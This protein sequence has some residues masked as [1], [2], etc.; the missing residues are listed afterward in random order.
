MHQAGAKGNS[1]NPRPADFRKKIVCSPNLN[2]PIRGPGCGA[3][4][5]DHLPGGPAQRAE[6][7]L[8][9]GRDQAVVVPQVD[10][11]GQARDDQAAFGRR[12]VH[13]PRVAD[14]LEDVLGE[15]D[16][17]AL[18]ELAHAAEQVVAC[19]GF[20]PAHRV[21]QFL[22]GFGQ[23]ESGRR[24]QRGVLGD[25]GQVVLA[26]RLAGEQRQEP[27]QVSVHGD[28]RLADAPGVVQAGDAGQRLD[29]TQAE[30]FEHR[31]AVGRDLRTRGLDD[32]GDIH[33]D[34]AGRARDDK[35]L[36]EFAQ[37][38]RWVLPCPVHD[39]VGLAVADAE[40][41]VLPLDC[42][43]GN[44]AFGAERQP[45]P[46]RRLGRGVGLSLR[47]R[48]LD[49]GQCL[50]DLGRLVAQVDQRPAAE[51]ALAGVRVELG[52]EH[53]RRTAQHGLDHGGDRVDHRRR[54]RVVPRR[55][56][57]GAYDRL[58]QLRKALLDLLLGQQL[59]RLVR[60]GRIGLGHARPTQIE[61]ALLR[62]SA[63]DHRVLRR[64]RDTQRQAR[65][66]PHGQHHHQFHD[67]RNETYRHGSVS[68]IK[69]TG[70]NGV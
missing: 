15:L 45:V 55:L 5:A 49:L 69:R 61:E 39:L 70:V 20:R 12:V 23:V 33:V 10:H 52:D 13:P 65:A 58:F 50:L 51:S 11:G 9:V 44:H 17:H 67:A 4:R 24:G 46:F 57:R 56:A 53:G 30:G 19:P 27:R 16:L 21:E 6:D 43:L 60:A 25:H 64:G 34:H 37:P 26:E 42:P 22:V 59:F 68:L 8:G 48:L 47:H 1:K 14:R 38:G 2:W 54:F 66:A 28:L 29:A 31:P 40:N 3:V 18:F 7:Q 62:S 32:P 35:L 63:A 36:A 41:Q